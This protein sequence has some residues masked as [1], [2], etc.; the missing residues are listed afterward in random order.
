MSKQVQEIELEKLKAIC[1]NERENLLDCRELERSTLYA[2]VRT[3][4][5]AEKIRSQYDLLNIVAKA[6]TRTFIFG[7][8]LVFHCALAQ[9]SHKME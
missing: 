7:F 4:S 5:P 9:Q 8:C 1:Y 2:N 6:K 3:E